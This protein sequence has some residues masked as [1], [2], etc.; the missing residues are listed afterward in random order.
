MT[1][2]RGERK[3]I[4]VVDDTVGNTSMLVSL[5]EPLGF[6]VDTAFNG[7]DALNAARERQP[8]LVLMDL[9]MPVMDGLEA[10]RLMRADPRFDR[11]A[12]IGA[13]ASV[14]DSGNKNEFIRVCDD[15]VV[16]PIRIDLLLEKIGSR[17]EIEWEE[18]RDH[19]FGEGN[20]RRSG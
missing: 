12:I 5:L 9:V 2:Y 3:R 13:S 4:L 19:R 7:E 17:M 8:D 20:V 10:A 6:K 1:G 16:K 11:T 14:T 18:Q 15:F